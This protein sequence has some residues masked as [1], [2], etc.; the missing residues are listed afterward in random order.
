M[1]KISSSLL[2]KIILSLVLILANLRAL[3]FVFLFP[4]TARPLSAAWFE[5]MLWGIAFIAVL[6]LLNRE[7]QMAEYL[8]MWRQNW[9]LALFIFLAIMSVIWSVGPVATSFRVLELFF[10]TVIGSYYGMRIGPEKM[11]QVL[12][13]FGAVLYILS[14]AL[15]YGA[16]PTGT[17]YWNPFQGAWRGVYWH[18]NHLASI[19][20]LF[21]VVYLCRLILAFQKKN[22]RGILDGIFFLLSLVILYFA[23][24]AT[25]Y[26]VFIVLNLSVFFILLWLR[27]NAHLQ[28]MHYLLVLIG[29]TLAFI[30]VLMNL[31]VVF[32]FF[33]RNSTMTGRVGLWSQLLDIASRRLWLGHGFGAVW[34]LDSFRAQVQQLTGWASQPLIGDN[35]FLDIYLHLGII[36]LTLLISVLTFAAIHSLRYAVGQK[37]LVSFFP[38]LVLIYAL[39][40]NIT[41]SLFAETEV[42]V[43]FLIVAVLFMTT[44]GI[45]SRQFKP[46]AAGEDV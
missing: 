25:G 44:R 12:F 27:L 4:D 5:I 30:L 9:M 33:H 14:I 8:A 6:Y 40:A 16:P 43:W 17:M 37:T 31:D 36:G 34:M 45:Q 38:L 26:I 46:I 3:I 42:F 18:R 24:S 29:G 7:C 10:A 23:R 15:V 20:A 11:M 19:T 32:G 1:A 28:R 22:A 35:G 13:W 39:F 2:E 21:S 41:F